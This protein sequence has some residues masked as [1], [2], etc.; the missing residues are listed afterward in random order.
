MI[1]WSVSTAVNANS[2][3]TWP[4]LRALECL[5]TNL[6][7]RFYLENPLS[8]CQEIAGTM[9]DYD[10]GRSRLLRHGC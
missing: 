4:I 5:L 1:F 2:S 9:G 3:A 10:P 7:G 6:N 8:T